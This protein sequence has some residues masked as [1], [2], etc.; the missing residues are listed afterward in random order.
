MTPDVKKFFQ[1]NPDSKY[2]YLSAHI[3]VPNPE[4]TWLPDWEEEPWP[5]VNDLVAPLRS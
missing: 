5:T 2:Y 1:D 4:L 3:R